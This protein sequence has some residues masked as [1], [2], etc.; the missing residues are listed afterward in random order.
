MEK[1]SIALRIGIGVVGVIF[2]IFITL[3]VLFGNRNKATQTNAKLDTATQSQIDTQVLPTE[4]ETTSETMTETETEIE[5]E[6]ETI[7][8]TE[9]EPEEHT[10]PARPA[11]DG[12]IIVCLDPGHGGYDPGANN[13]NYKEKDFNLK[14]GLKLKEILE[15]N[16]VTVI[17][18]RDT[19]KAIKELRDRVDYAYGNGADM[20]VSLHINAASTGV[21]GEHG[22]LS[23]VTRSHYQA[24]TAICEDIYQHSEDL[25][26]AILNELNAIG[27]EITTAGKASQN[28]G[29]LRRPS[30]EGRTYPDGS[31][32]DY[33]GIIGAS[34]EYGM[35]STIIEH[36]FITSETDL[37]TW[38]IPEE[39]IAKL[40]EADAKGILEYIRT[41]F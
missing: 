4:T 39:G 19:D 15:S 13:G 32:R 21:V 24:P 10:P 1:R 37:S 20:L 28:N 29:F 6:S 31:T 18:T 8:V 34:T 41:H 7:A 11:E 12:T 30:G 9:T 35:P 14:I 16:G 23:I 36:A 33:Y 17:M 27:I 2:I 22:C 38:L 26:K 40:A 5:T 25:G 3:M